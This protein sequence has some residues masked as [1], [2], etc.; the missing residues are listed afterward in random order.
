MARLI[1]DTSGYLAGMI[2]SHP[3]RAAIREILAEAHEPP[4]ISPLVIAELDYMVLDRAGVKAEAGMLGELTGGAYDLADVSL[5]DLSSGRDLTT[6]YAALKIGL[7]DAVT[8]ILAARYQTSEILTLDER[9]FRAVPP[10]TP[11]FPAY[12]LLPMDR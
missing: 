2:K 1:I 8:M 11:K 6:K 12:R 4:V 9:H 5:D 7:T 10:L 3:L